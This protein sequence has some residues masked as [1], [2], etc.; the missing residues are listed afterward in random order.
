MGKQAGFTD[1]EFFCQ[2]SGKHYTVRPGLEQGKFMI[3]V[4]TKSNV[5]GRGMGTLNLEARGHI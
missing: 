3:C 5:F 2:T 4:F 1:V